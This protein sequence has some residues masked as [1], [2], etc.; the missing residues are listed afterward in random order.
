LRYWTDIEEEV[1]EQGV[2]ALQAKGSVDGHQDESTADD[3]HAGGQADVLGVEDG[4][5]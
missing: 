2:E 1:L 5:D 4:A 3:A